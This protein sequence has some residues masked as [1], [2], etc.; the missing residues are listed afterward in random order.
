MKY[1]KPEYQ[2]HF[3]KYGIAA[4]ASDIIIRAAMQREI[5]ER[6][7]K[8]TT[9]EIVAISLFPIVVFVGLMVFDLLA[10]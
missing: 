10:K 6:Q 3:E 8:A 7:I 5:A 2:S 4:R 1:T 9:R